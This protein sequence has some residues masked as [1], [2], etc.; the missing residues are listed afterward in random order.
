MP[1]YIVILN[2]ADFVIL[3]EN[4]SCHPETSRLSV[5]LNGAVRRSEGSGVSLQG[6]APISSTRFFAHSQND[7]AALRMT[8]PRPLRHC[9]ISGPRTSTFCNSL[10]YSTM[11]NNLVRGPLKKVRTTNN[12]FSYRAAIQEDTN[13][14]CSWS[15]VSSFFSRFLAALG[16][17]MKGVQND[18]EA[19]FRL[20]RTT[21]RR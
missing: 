11:Q 18:R 5:I 19:E 12:D 13:F 17:T 21:F 4:A 20:A 16:M 6:S 8:M 15:V 3:I 7:N 10:R 1:Y 9:T 2:G 14:A